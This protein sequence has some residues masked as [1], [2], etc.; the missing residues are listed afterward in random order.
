MGTRP[1]SRGRL[2][3][4]S[5]LLTADGFFK[6]TETTGL[7]LIATCRLLP[8]FSRKVRRAPDVVRS[9]SNTAP[10]ID[11]TA[12]RQDF[13]LRIAGRRS[14]AATSRPLVVFS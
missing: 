13:D 3:A 5:C 12:A 2:A 9:L 10:L 7:L 1:S 11:V 6:S 14:Q 4:D 8:A